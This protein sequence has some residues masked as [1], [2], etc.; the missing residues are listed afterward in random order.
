M[1]ERIISA[2][3]P[4]WTP[5]SVTHVDGAEEKKKKLHYSREK[6]EEEG[7]QY[8]KFIKC[9]NYYRW[10]NTDCLQSNKNN[11][12]FKFKNEKSNEHS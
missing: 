8:L 6:K 4:R 12:K 1:T 11:N 3:K 7:T 2:F 5:Y 10:R 9:Q